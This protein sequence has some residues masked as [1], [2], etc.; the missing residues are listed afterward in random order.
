MYQLCGMDISK[1]I[2]EVREEKRLTQ[3]EVA[4]KL[5]M[6]R[7]NYARLE[8]RGNKLTIE[9]LEK[10]AGALGVSVMELLTGEGQ[11]VQDSE[12][13]ER[14]RKRVEELEDRIKDKEES[15]RRIKKDLSEAF[16]LEFIYT[17]IRLGLT[18]ENGEIIEKEK[19]EAEF[20]TNTLVQE[21]LSNDLIDEKEQLYQ[22]W[23][24]NRQQSNEAIKKT[25]AGIAAKIYKVLSEQSLQKNNTNPISLN[26]SSSKIYPSLSDIL[27]KEDSE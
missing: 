1:S 20:Y 21:L 8:A 12:E 9:Q 14:L 18:N 24:E 7:S 3:L 23:I 22:K 2:R 5:Q 13:V 16:N 17:A 27:K 6:E 15:N 10:I 19:V 25:F 26:P 11:K 4:D